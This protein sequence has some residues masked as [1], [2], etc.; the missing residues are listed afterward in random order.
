MIDIHCHMLP[1]VDDGAKDWEQSL[2]MARLAVKDGISGIICT[3]HCS[4]RFPGN[5]RSAV[6]AVVEEFRKRLHDEDI[7]LQ[8]YPGAEL[9]IDFD[10]PEKIAAGE[11]MTTNDDL[12]FALVEIP[13]EFLPPYLD[14]LFWSLQA[15]GIVPILGHPELNW[16]LMKNPSLLLNWVEGGVL[17]QITGNSLSGLSGR[18]IREFSSEL[19]RR[20]MVHFIATDSHNSGGRPPILSTARELCASIIGIE[21]TQMIFSGNPSSILQGVVP[22]VS[23]PLPPEK[24]NKPSFIQR[25]ISRAAFDSI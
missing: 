24:K 20:R 14:R 10:L 7:P 3:P 25:F 21:E 2:E 6:L 5:D 12:K 1:G 11:V 9:V 22:Q 19:L 8:I 15:K 18:R 4:P 16:Q 17:V 13:H 23:D